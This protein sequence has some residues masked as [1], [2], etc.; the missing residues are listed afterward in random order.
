M[1]AYLRS[2]VPAAASVAVKVIHPYS[3]WITESGLRVQ[4]A[5]GLT[6]QHV[7]QALT[8]LTTMIVRAP[9]SPC[10]ERGGRAA[11]E[12]LRRSPRKEGE[13]SPSEAAED[14]VA[15]SGFSRRQRRREEG[16]QPQS[17]AAEE[18]AKQVDLPE[19]ATKVELP[20]VCVNKVSAQPLR[21]EIGEALSVEKPWDMVAGEM[22]ASL[23]GF[24]FKVCLWAAV[25]WLWMHM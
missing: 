11:L 13:Q 2:R 15:D 12:L 22:L 23:V 6:Q 24:R 4:V 8:F 19:Q 18:P 17:E 20:E 14:F 21:V 16:E 10:L 9:P 5:S 1:E 7:Q 3:E 25:P